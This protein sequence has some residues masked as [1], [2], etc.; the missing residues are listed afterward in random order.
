MKYPTP[1]DIAEMKARGYEAETIRRAEWQMERGKEAQKLCVLIETA[2]HGVKLGDGVG[3]FQAQGL[4]DYENAATCAA[5]RAKDEK[6]DWRRITAADLNRCHSSLSFFDAEGM[7]FHLPAYL[8]LDLRGECDMGITFHLT[9]A[10]G[11]RPK[12]DLLTP[13]QRST[14]RT[15]LL[16][17]LDDPNEEFHHAD[18]RHALDHY[19]I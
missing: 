5:Y 10:L 18:I 12:F 11:D 2:F 16:F 15:Y 9:Y 4:D 6:E 13:E 8:I 17:L 14:V 7:R 1:E 19:W 3:L